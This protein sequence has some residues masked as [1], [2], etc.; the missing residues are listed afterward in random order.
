MKHCLQ[1]AMVPLLAIAGA[2]PASA[3]NLTVALYQGP[4]G[5]AIKTCIVEPFVQAT[6]IKVTPELAMSV[7]VLE[8]L[9][10]QRR[11]PMIDVAWMDGGVSELAAAD[12]LVAPINTSAIPG[13]ANLVPQGVHKNATGVTYA[14]STGFVGFGLVHATQLTEEPPS[15][16]WDLWKPG[17]V[18]RSSLPSPSHPMGVPLLLQLNKLLGGAPSDLEPII[19]KYAQLA[20][21]AFADSLPSAVGDL[22]SGK[23]SVSAQYASIAWSL[24]DSGLPITYSA[25]KE[26]ALASDIRIHIVRGGRNAVHARRFVNFAIADPQA[27]CMAERMF[28]VPANKG[29]VLSEQAKARMPWGKGGSIAD[30][31]MIDWNQVH[32]ARRNATSAWKREIPDNKP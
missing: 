15:S 19:K 4:W 5:E 2:Q 17:F 12:G 11:N 26:G 22:R 7:E 23:T 21:P 13:I 9:R 28:L 31:V 20:S 1:I 30:L 8:R 16:W 14:L 25:P 3:R 6:H 29:V 27:S 10:E 18:G 24:A 32:E